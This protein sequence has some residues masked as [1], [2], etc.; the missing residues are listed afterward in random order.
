MT[1][2]QGGA[3]MSGTPRRRLYRSETDRVVAGVAGGLAA[4]LEVDATLVRVAWVAAGFFSFG[5]PIGLYLIMWLLIPRESRLGASPADTAA[6]AVEEL[7]EKLHK[8]TG[9]PKGPD[10]TWRA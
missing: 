9:G 7:R 2:D 5:L 8:V 1:N 3:G 4:Y 10:R 6:D